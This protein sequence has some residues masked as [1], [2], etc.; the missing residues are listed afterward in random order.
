MGVGLVNKQ[1][2]IQ[3]VDFRYN[4]NGTILSVDDC[5]V[6]TNR[7][8]NIYKFPY[9]NK[10]LLN[11]DQDSFT[12]SIIP[13]ASSFTTK[14]FTFSVKGARWERMGQIV[15]G[16]TDYSSVRDHSI[17]ILNRTWVIPDTPRSCINLAEQ[18]VSPDP[19]FSNQERFTIAMT[20]RF[21]GTPGNYRNIWVF[22]D[23][24]DVLRCE[25]NSAN[26]FLYLY[27]EDY[28]G[29]DRRKQ[30]TFPKNEANKMANAEYLP[31]NI[32][33]PDCTQWTQVIVSVS[34]LKYYVWVNGVQVKPL[35]SPI[36]GVITADRQ[37]TTAN[38]N[39]FY[40]F[41]RRGAN[42]NNGFGCTA[43]IKH[44]AI[45][46]GVTLNNNDVTD[47]NNFYGFTF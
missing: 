22:N 6:Y 39:K 9:P 1:G 44:L 36:D 37:L 17:D 38:T 21:H 2:A 32:G 3:R 4:N 26:N 11:L 19:A 7:N 24:S 47:L 12:T 18:V 40:I 29:T 42:S 43:E 31:Y 30:L 16:I 25:V 14:D 27:R 28:T 46:K 8:G 41:T 5:D 23:T 45:W 20:F 33:R 34:G 35:N 10:L 15:S 13:S